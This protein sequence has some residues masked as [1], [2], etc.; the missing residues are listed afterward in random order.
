MKILLF[1]YITGGGLIDHTLPSSL[2]NE[3]KIM[4][5]AIANDFGRISN[6]DVYAFRDYRLGSNTTPDHEIAIKPGRTHTEEIELLFK[7]IDA[8]LIIAPETNDILTSLCEEYSNYTFTLLNSTVDAIRLT[9]NKLD[10]Y[11]YLLESDVVQIPTYHQGEINEIRA[12]KYVMKPI[13]G[14]GCENLFI[15]RNHDDVVNKLEKLGYEN[16][17]IQPFLTGIHASICLLCWDGESH[18]LSVNEQCIKEEQDTLVLKGCRVNAFD[19]S[20]FEPFCKNLIQAFPGLR[21]YIGVDI[22]ITENEIIL[23]ELNPRITTS[24]VGLRDALGINP[25]KLM[26]ECFNQKKLIS[27]EATK[28]NCITVNIENDRAA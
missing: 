9:S 18:I 5:N 16:F 3:G 20:R 22:L 26:L 17:I 4:L 25:A 8:V 24:Y 28:S 12:N 10:T 14:V 21:G 6:V 7:D 11:Q 19:K 27:F 15:A 2:V 23:V 13:Y 1:E